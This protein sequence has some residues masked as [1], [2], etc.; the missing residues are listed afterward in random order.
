LHAALCII[1]REGYG[2][3]IEESVRKARYMA[4]AIFARPEFELLLE[5]ETNILNYRYVGAHPE[6]LND[7]A[8][9]GATFQEEINRFNGRLHKAQRQAGRSFVS[10]TTLTATKYGHGVS[11]VS[12]RAVVAN[13][14]TTEADIDF[15]LDDQIKIAAQLL[16]SSVNTGS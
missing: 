10:R 2:W 7:R 12:L 9:S 5:P 16:E 13:P 8:R 14:L 6:R 11:I 15:V 1:G 4:K 3:L